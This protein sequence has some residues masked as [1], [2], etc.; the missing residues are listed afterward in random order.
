MFSK[1]FTDLDVGWQGGQVFVLPET[2]SPRHFQLAAAENNGFVIKVTESGT[3]Q[4][5]QE[6]LALAR[7]RE[8][9]EHIPGKC[10]NHTAFVSRA[11][12]PSLLGTVHDQGIEEGLRAL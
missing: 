8:V 1:P 3:P 4:T 7:S 10:N 2:V 5:Y 11:D 6:V 9:R 12:L